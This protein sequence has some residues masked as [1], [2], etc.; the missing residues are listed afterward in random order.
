MRVGGPELEPHR[1]SIRKLVTKQKKKAALG[2]FV[3]Y[4]M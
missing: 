4:G 1:G 2:R 3:P